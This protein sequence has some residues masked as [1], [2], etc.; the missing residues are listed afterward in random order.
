MPN[1]QQQPPLVYADS[2]V[3]LDLIKK[4]TCLHPATQEKRW[5]VAARFFDAVDEGRVRLAAS[6]LTQSEVACN[7]DSRRDSQRIRDLLDVWWTD[8]AT[9]WRELDRYIAREAA[10]LAGTWHAKH[11]PG[12]RFN[13]ADA[14]HLA[15]AVDLGCDY[16]FT[17]DGG[18]PHGH[19]VEGVEV[20]RPFQA[21][22]ASLL[23]LAVGE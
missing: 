2:D 7:G 21:W 12:K 19:T 22:P 16:L 1:K 8:P 20:R 10:R 18:F 9:E 11:E 23:D 5:Q 13:S 4:S 17:Y 3:Y 15:T 6:A 14:V